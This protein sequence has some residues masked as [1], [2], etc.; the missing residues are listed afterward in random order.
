M[1]ASYIHTAVHPDSSSVF[2]CPPLDKV[3]VEVCARFMNSFGCLKNVLGL[4]FRHQCHCLLPLT[5]LHV[6]LSFFLVY[7]EHTDDVPPK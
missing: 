5:S 6:L 1:G 4:S 3:R 7:T 2:I